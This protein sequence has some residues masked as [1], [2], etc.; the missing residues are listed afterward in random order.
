MVVNSFARPSFF[1]LFDQLMSATNPQSNQARWTI[2]GVEAERERHSFAGPDH[3]VTIEAV[4][5]TRR[6][7][8]GWSLLVVKEYWWAGAANKALKS[9]RW[10]R[11]VSGAR[12]DLLAWL[13]TQER[14][15]TGQP[16]TAH[17]AAGPFAPDGPD[18]SAGGG[19]LR[20]AGSKTPASA[21]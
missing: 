17:Q 15:M 2:D 20:P 16:S 7:Q 13:R 8:R 21:G 12:S 4:T 6:G 10:A 5:L 18:L 11:P 1:R 9:F 14:V 19:E 3:G